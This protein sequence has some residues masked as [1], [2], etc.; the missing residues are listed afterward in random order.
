MN[1]RKVGVR[2]QRHDVQEFV[3]KVWRFDDSALDAYSRGR[4][5]EEVLALFP[6]L[7]SKGLQLELSYE[8]SL[9]GRISIDGDADMH[10]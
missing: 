10:T 9:V 8:D 6:A 2:W 4:V 1:Q 5:E 7:Q 3:Q